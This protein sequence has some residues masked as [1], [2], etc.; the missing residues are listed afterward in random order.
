MMKNKSMLK[1]IFSL[2]L[3]LSLSMSFLT[4]MAR[5]DELPSEDPSAHIELVLP[6]TTGSSDDISA[7]LIVDQDV[8]ADE[9]ESASSSE[10][11]VLDDKAVVSL[12]GREEN[13]AQSEDDKMNLGE[14]GKKNEIAFDN[15]KSDD[16]ADLD[17]VPNE[18]EEGEP[19][20]V[21]VEDGCGDPAAAET[22]S[23][24]AEDEVGYSDRGTTSD[25][26]DWELTKDATT[27]KYT[28]TI[29]FISAPNG[30]LI[31]AED[32]LNNIEA[33]AAEISAALAAKYGVM[34]E[35]DSA[36]SPS[37]AAD[38][39]KFQIFLT[40]NG[41]EDHTYRYDAEKLEQMDGEFTL[42]KVDEYG[43]PIANSETSFLL[44]HINET[45]DPETSERVEV[46]MYCSYDHET[47]T[48]TFIPTESTIQ[49]INGRLEILY[50]MMKDTVYYLQEVQ[51][52]TGY[53]LDPSIHIIMEKKVW[54][55][56][57]ESFRNQF[58]YLGE[59]TED[60][61]G[62]IALDVKFVD[63]KHS[64][65]DYVSEVTPAPVGYPDPAAEEAAYVTPEPDSVPDSD[66]PFVDN[67]ELPINPDLVPQNP[68]TDTE[69]DPTPDRTVG[70]PA[71][72]PTSINNIPKTGDIMDGFVLLAITSALGLV[73][74]SFSDRK[75]A[76]K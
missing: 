15:E 76:V 63:V 69:D 28:L 59:F 71:P 38:I 17:A 52:P 31:I 34:W 67:H 24:E 26:L 43:N 64:A 74:V 18:E 39:Q 14:Q 16:E 19:A 70:E 72:A 29:K 7:V 45:I 5:A 53:E 23:I 66:E 1:R 48:Y 40:G 8:D 57:E 21:A 3:A 36:T 46:K 65:G 60:E 55:T 41:N 56:E 25:G 12:Q 10:A 75:K 9:D 20:V 61:S 37:G 62:R 2:A 11:G 33:Y 35:W 13:P 49:T 68:P 42:V 73:A 58:H 51:A 30:D 44:W 4:S 27:G 22:H 32:E 6:S 50:A 47:N 54:E